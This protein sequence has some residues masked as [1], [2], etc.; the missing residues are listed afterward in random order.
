MNKE[1]EMDKIK[2]EVYDL[3][4]S[5]LYKNRIENNLKPVNGEGSLDTKIVFVGE[6]PGK[7]EAE[8]GIPFCGPS[9]KIL[10]ELFLHIGLSRD[11][12]FITNIV[13]DRPPENRD[14]HPKEID[15]YSP[16]LDKQIEIIKPKLIVPLGLHAV[17]Y[18]LNRYG[19]IELTIKISEIHGKT[20]NTEMSYGKIKI[21]P[22]FHPAVA[23]YNPLKKDEL[24]K[25]FEI[26]KKHI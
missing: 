9:G 18:I 5:P 2:K 21:I 6:A 3:V 11:K 25:D 26:I 14:P 13:K 19:K 22:L 24:K 10:D 7:N 16:F 15:I 1:K 8:K 12:V 17:K 23:L 4:N 20:F